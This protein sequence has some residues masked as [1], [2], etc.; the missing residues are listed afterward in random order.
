M[1]WFKLNFANEPCFNIITIAGPSAPP[2]NVT[3]LVINSTSISVFWNPPPFDDQN[4][5]ITSYRVIVTNQNTT[6]ASATINSTSFVV[7]NLQE[8]QQYSI[9][10][11]AMTAVGIGPFSNPISDQTLEDGELVILIQYSVSQL[12]T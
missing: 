1:K 2:Q 7:N 4:G 8:F 3:T 6:V 11:A 10:V 5:V 9:E 12:C